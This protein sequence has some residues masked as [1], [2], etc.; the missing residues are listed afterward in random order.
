MSFIVNGRAYDFGS[1]TIRI[2]GQSIEEDTAEISYKDN[3]ERGEFFGAGRKRKARTG[4]RYKAE[5]SFKVLR[6]THDA[7]TNILGGDGFM[8]EE[9]EVTCSYGDEG[10]PIITDTLRECLISSN[11]A[12]LSE[13][14]D[15]AMVACDLDISEILWNGK[16]GIKDKAP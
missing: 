15:A 8:D 9:C 14:T 13:G 5:G 2:K 1:L 3:V 6:I 4:G 12:S 7:L 10:Q 11:D 16:K